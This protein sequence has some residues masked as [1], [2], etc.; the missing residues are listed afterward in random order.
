[1]AGSPSHKPDSGFHLG[2][3]ENSRNDLAPLHVRLGYK[4]HLI[5]VIHGFLIAYRLELENILK[6][7]YEAL[8]QPSQPSRL[9][10][11]VFNR[12]RLQ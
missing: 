5:Q 4:L 12:E 10:I 3:S 6:L 8:K 11:T 7:P 9:Q 1:M 2:G